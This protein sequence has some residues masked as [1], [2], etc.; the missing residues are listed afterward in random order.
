MVRKL[1]RISIQ[2]F[3]IFN[4]L[5]NISNIKIQF[6][7][8]T[9]VGDLPICISLINNS[10]NLIF[11]NLETYLGGGGG[12]APSSQKVGSLLKSPLLAKPAWKNDIQGNFFAECTK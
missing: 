4:K 2:Y 11:I 8:K 6:L 3:V 1:W 12:L 5:F 10:K 7:P 9:L